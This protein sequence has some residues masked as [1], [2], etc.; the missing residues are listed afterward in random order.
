MARSYRPGIDAARWLLDELVQRLGVES[1]WS[2]GDTDSLR[3]SAGP[4]CTL[5]TVAD[6]GVHTPHLA[7]L[8]VATDAAFDGD[9]ATATNVTNGF[10]GVTGLARWVV[11]PDEND[12]EFTVAVVSSF[13][14]APGTVSGL[15][16]LV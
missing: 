12:G 6:T 5:F 1:E 13:L 8:T 10:N 4:F 16:P 2:V 9:L 15:L 3:W 7:R 11:R 14:V